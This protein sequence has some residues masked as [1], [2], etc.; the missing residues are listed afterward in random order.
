LLS[1][2]D[3]IV[4]RIISDPEIAENSDHPL[5]GELHDLMSPNSSMKDP[6]TNTFVRQGQQGISQVP[7]EDGDRQITREVTGEVETVSET[8]VTFPMCTYPSYRL[9]NAGGTQIEFSTGPTQPGQG[10]AV[11]VDG[12]WKIDRFEGFEDQESCEEDAR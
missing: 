9:Y 7:F 6:L 8:E 5:Y 12:H 2:F 3:A 10:T 11:L 4:N 1:R